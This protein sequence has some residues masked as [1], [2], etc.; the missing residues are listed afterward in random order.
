[1]S[2]TYSPAR[3]VMIVQDNGEDVMVELPE[4]QELLD[5]LHEVRRDATAAIAEKDVQI[6]TLQMRLHN[7]A[8]SKHVAS[9]SMWMGWLAALVMAGAA[10]A[11]WAR[12][13]G[14]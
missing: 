1:M 6:L 14:W 12:V 5:E 10:V 13:W 11:G 7:I 3:A 2:K 4:I 9:T 8:P